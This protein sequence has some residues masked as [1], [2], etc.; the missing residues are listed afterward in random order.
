M[1][2]GNPDLDCKSTKGNKLTIKESIDIHYKRLNKYGRS[3][4]DGDMEYIPRGGIYIYTARGN[5]SYH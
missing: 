4:Y 5:K 2:L 3:G 1:L